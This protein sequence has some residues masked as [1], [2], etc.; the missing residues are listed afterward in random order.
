MTSK[1]NPFP[2]PRLVHLDFPTPVDDWRVLID[3]HDR[4]D[5]CSAASQIAAKVG[6]SVLMFCLHHSRDHEDRLIE[7]GC[8]LAVRPATTAVV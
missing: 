6:D 3:W 1:P 8:A 2:D 5:V 7:R 4:C